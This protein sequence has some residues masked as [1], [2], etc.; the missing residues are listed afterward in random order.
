MTLISGNL[1]AYRAT[2]SP[3]VLQIRFPEVLPLEIGHL[4]LT[5]I[6]ESLAELATGA[7]VTV[8]P[9]KH[10]VRI[11]PINRLKQ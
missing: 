3:S 6:R 8:E 9:L 2:S 4:V 11:L 10:R 5:A 7:L 1:H